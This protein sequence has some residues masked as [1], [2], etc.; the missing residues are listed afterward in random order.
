MSKPISA[1]YMADIDIFFVE[2]RSDTTP[3]ART[4]N[5][6]LWVNLDLDADGEPVAIEFVDASAGISLRGVPAAAEVA[7]LARG[8]GLPISTEDVPAEA[9]RPA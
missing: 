2:Y 5:L 8:F 7:H 4:R 6:G 1:K 3:I 9:S